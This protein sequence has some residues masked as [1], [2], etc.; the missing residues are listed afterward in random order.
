MRIVQYPHPALRYRA[1]AVKQI[2]KPLRLQVGEMFDLMYEAKGLGLAATQVALPYQL[3]VMNE[4]SDP[5]QRDFERVYV[6]PVITKR[7][8]MVDDEEGCLS[9]PGMFVSVKRA[10]RVV[11]EAYDLRG[12]KVALKAEGIVARLWQHELDHHSGT[13][14][15]DRFSAVAKLSRH[16]EI[17]AFESKFKKAQAMGEFPPDAEIEKFMH[18]LSVEMQSAG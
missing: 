12:E 3:L 1:T 9:F 11:V 16:L 5:D 10:R 15:I 17:K 8:G 14:F 13:L 18:A 6:N 4:Q 7:E 2:D